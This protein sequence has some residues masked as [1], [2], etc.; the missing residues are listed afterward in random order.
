[1]NQKVNRRCFDLEEIN[2]NLN[3]QDMT[4]SVEDGETL[5]DMLRIRLGMTGTKKGCEVGECG[6]CTVLID[7]IA[8]DSCLYLAKLADGKKLI[9]IEGLQEHEGLSRL[10]QA[11]I[12]CGAVQCGFC[13]PGLILSS[14]AFLLKNPKPTKEDIKKGLAG[15]MCR[16]AAY[17]QVI[18]AVLEASRKVRE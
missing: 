13:T 8:V 15:N 12:D 10:Q 6:A 9:T 3:G 11:Y 5:L 16:C 4:V 18:D 14:Y 7:N 1:M 2:I 17:G